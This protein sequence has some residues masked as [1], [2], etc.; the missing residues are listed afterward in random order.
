[1]IDSK[2]HEFEL[3]HHD[4]IRGLFPGYPDDCAKDRPASMTTWEFYIVVNRTMH[5]LGTGIYDN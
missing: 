4:I 2:N 5:D 1:M 3:S